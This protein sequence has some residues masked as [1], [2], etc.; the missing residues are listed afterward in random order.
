M[1]V[2]TVFE[3]EL[4]KLDLVFGKCVE[5]LLFQNLFL[6][7]LGELSSELKVFER[8]IKVTTYFHFGALEKDVFASDVR[9]VPA[10][11]DFELFRQMQI[12]HFQTGGENGQVNLLV[13]LVA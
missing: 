8:F 10:H 6:Q 4:H 13:V 12:D 1:Q 3:Q 9:T 5:H 7:R 2:D 11:D